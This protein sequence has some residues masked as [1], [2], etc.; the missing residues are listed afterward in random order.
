MGLGL[1]C[2]V[3]CSVLLLL[4]QLLRREDHPT[5]P[6]LDSKECKAAK[7][8]MLK[9]KNFGRPCAAMLKAQQRA[10][11]ACPHIN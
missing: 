11:A 10:T 2:A 1:R 4:R 5:G 9:P 7:E 3:E 6:G 8:N